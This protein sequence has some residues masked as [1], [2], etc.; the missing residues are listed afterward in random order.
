MSSFDEESARRKR[1][2]RDLEEHQRFE[3]AMRLVDDVFWT[4]LGCAAIGAA[5]GFVLGYLAGS[6]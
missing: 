1:A 2:I 3:R 5:I 6:S 4:C